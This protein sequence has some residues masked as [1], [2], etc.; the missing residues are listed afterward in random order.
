MSDSSPKH[1]QI[2]KSRLDWARHRIDEFI[3]AVDEFLAGK[4]YFIARKEKREGEMGRIILIMRIKKNAH[5]KLRFR[6]GDAIHNLRATVDN[7]IYGLAQTRNSSDNFGLEFHKTK[8]GFS[9]TYA[10]KIKCLPVEIQDWIMSE[11]VHNRTNGPSLLHILNRMWNPDK[12]RAPALIA[13]AIP[14]G[15]CFPQEFWTSSLRGFED[16]DKVAWGLLPIKDVVNFQPN[17]TIDVSFGKESAASDKIA[18][19]FL[20]DAHE[21][22]LKQVIPKFEPFL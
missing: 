9:R 2:T 1:M 7:L 11:Q 3:S 13:G 22:I 18:R 12:H 8:E 17:F 6:A 10:A 4:P 20:L 16:G 15:H 19:T 21:H 14:E 5:R